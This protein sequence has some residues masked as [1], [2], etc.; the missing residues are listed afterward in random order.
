MAARAE[1][2]AATADRVQLPRWAAGGHRE[3]VGEGEE[4]GG[5]EPS[6]R[7]PHN[8]KKIYFKYCQYSGC[9]NYIPCRKYIPRVNFLTF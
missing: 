2:S 4:P 5:T 7:G 8:P 6:A 1:A 3:V 9:R